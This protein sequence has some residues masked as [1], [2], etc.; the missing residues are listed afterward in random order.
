MNKYE[1]EDIDKQLNLCIEGLILE[2]E[3]MK[4]CSQNNEN[5]VKCYEYFNNEKNFVI[6]M[7]LCDQNLA[8]LLLNKIVKY[9]KK[10]DDKEIYDIMYQ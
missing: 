9:K 8:K 3:N 10:F 1:L 7:E 2:F 4:L 5:S 6:I